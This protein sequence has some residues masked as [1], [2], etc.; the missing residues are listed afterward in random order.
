[1]Y[2]G[3]ELG[4]S[5]QCI[6]IHDYLQLL[7]IQYMAETSDKLATFKCFAENHCNEFITIN[8]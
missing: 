3:E 5:D 8:A 2:P 4:R 1:M 6:N 7:Q